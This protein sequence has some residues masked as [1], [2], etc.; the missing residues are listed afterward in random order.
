MLVNRAIGVYVRNHMGLRMAL[1][2]GMAVGVA[3]RVVAVLSGGSLRRCDE[4]TLKG[5]RQRRRRH[6]DDGETM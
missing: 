6:D 1:I 3:V 5:K 2:E 4:G